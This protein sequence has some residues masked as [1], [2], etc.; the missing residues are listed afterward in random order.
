MTTNAGAALA[1]KYSSLAL[2]AVLGA[3][4]LASLDLFIVNLAFPQISRSFSSASPQAMSWVLNAYLVTFAALLAPAGRLA[5][6]YGRRRVFE[7]GLAALSPLL[8]LIR[9]PKRKLV[10]PAAA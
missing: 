5:D 4:V 10:A 8:A 3:S 2:A 7:L 1:P 9:A 6:H